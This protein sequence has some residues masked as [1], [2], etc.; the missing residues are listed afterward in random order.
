[1]HF[2][3]VPTHRYSRERIQDPKIVY[4]AV[5]K[6]KH[7]L[8]NSAWPKDTIQ[9]VERNLESV[10]Q[11]IDYLRLQDGLAI[12]VSPNIS[13]FFLLPFQVKEKVV[14][15]KKFEIRDCFTTLSF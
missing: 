13:K 15:G 9:Q 10:R 5:E 3:V 12:F 1:M 4:K 6:A 14:L 7:I 8:K 11:K 2:I